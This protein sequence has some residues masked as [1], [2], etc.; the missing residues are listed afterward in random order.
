M[1]SVAR[2]G[3]D[4][5]REVEGVTTVRGLAMDAVQNAGNGHPGTAM[6]LAPL[7]H[8]L[9]TRVMRYDADSPE[10]FDR[11]RFV[12]SCGHASILLYSM[13][14]L[15]GT[16]LELDDIKQFRKWG[17]KT[18]GHPER[19]HTRGVEVT[20]GPLGQGFANAVGMAVAEANLRAR[21]GEAVCDHYTYVICSDGDL[22]E[23]ITHEA[24]SLAGHLGLGR[25]IAIYDDNHITI[26][27]PTELALTDDAAGRFRAYGWHVE[28]VGEIA[29]DLDALE[30]A[31]H[32]AKA[33]TDKPSM[34]VLRSH[35]G[36]PAPTKTD[37]SAAHGEPLGADEVAATK[38]ILGRNPQQSFVVPDDVLAM[39]RAAGRRHADAVD[40]WSDRVAALPDDRRA[41]FDAC[42]AGLP[43]PGWADRLPTYE[44]GK[45]V[46]TRQ[47]SG[48]VLNALVP[49]VPGLL[50]GGADLT[51]NT[52]TMVKAATKFGPSTP[53]GRLIHY[54]VREHGMGAIMNGIAAHGGLL[55]YGGTFFVF[56]DYMR[57]AVR[58]AAI[59]GCKVVY[60]WT[61][62]SIGVGEDGP[63]HQPIEHL[64]SLRAMPGLCVLRPA[65]A[66]EVAAAWRV[67]VEAGE[68]PIALVLSRQKVPVLVGTHERAVR[69]VARGAYVLS[70]AADGD[71]DVILLGT[72]SE[73][74]HC[75]AAAS[76]LADEGW[77]A[78]VVSMPSWDLFE[79]EDES[80]QESVL[81]TG[82]PVV[83]V[84]MGSSFGWERYAD[85][86]VTV[87]TYGA[88]GSSDKVIAEYGFDAD[89]VVEAALL[90]LDDDGED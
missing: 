51:G 28:E 67:V 54:G 43:M 5:S 59:S 3:L 90:L 79:A 46:P 88:S 25:L 45:E 32:R 89:S 23:G 68:H 15:S 84:E 48:D 1:T 34:I 10:W 74:Q 78:R 35:I 76:Q 36:Y 57:G 22:M 71:P 49:A 56:S 29:N 14:Y 41:E 65:D 39:Y 83:A 44:V 69:G 81:P 13:L 26:D 9:W 60:S 75:V 52:G 37:T 66:N 11:D 62:D 27:G 87:D 40:A 53:E 77:S 72:G 73:V 6:A 61:H 42:L 55:P 50:G 82:V 7:A 12:L 18:P 58:V 17:S 31:L 63:T 24:G 2:T 47:A 8:V 80:Y 38:T 16:D 21:F 20:T 33:V 70:D 19:G 86:A 30:A 64:A 4:P 85:L